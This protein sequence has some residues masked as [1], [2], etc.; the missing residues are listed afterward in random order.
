MTIIVRHNEKVKTPTGYYT[1]KNF[2]WKMKRFV[3]LII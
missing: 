2:N 3:K 1:K